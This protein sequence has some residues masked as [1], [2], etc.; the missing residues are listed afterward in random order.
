[1][2]LTGVGIQT[3]PRGGITMTTNSVGKSQVYYSIFGFQLASVTVRHAGV[4]IH[5][6]NMGSL[7]S[8]PCDCMFVKCGRK[9]AETSVIKGRTYLEVLSQ[10]QTNF[11]KFICL[12]YFYSRYHV[13]DLLR[14]FADKQEDTATTYVQ[15]QH[16]EVTTRPSF[17][18]NFNRCATS[19]FMLLCISESFIKKL[20]LVKYLVLI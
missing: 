7:V 17:C 10:K 18:Q 4:H 19:L 2:S 1:M 11:S 8:T 5:I 9:Q 14:K 6:C 15:G 20:D 12:T 3:R 16:W 13:E